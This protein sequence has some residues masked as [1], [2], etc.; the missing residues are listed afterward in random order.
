MLYTIRLIQNI[1]NV[2]LAKL[3]R[4]ALIEFDA[5]GPGTAYDDPATDILYELSQEKG[6]VY[7]VAEEENKIVGGAGIYPTT[8][9]PP[10]ICELVKFY[11]RISNR[12]T[13]LGRI[14]MEK[15]LSAAR[16]KGFKY[17]Y[18]ETNPQLQLALKFYEKFGFEYLKGPLGNSGHYGCKMWMLKELPRNNT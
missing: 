10:D 18:L 11:I 12:G 4:D 2:V 7:F 1:D 5:A 8:G 9:L 3:V 16:E 15:C 17:M 14:L 13:G 6:A